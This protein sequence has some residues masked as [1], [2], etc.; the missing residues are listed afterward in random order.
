MYNH[1][2]AEATWSYTENLVSHSKSLDT[3]TGCTH[4]AS[5][6]HPG[7][8][9][10]DAGTFQGADFH[11]MVQASHTWANSSNNSGAVSTGRPRIARIHPKDIQNISE[12]QADCA[13][14]H[15]HHILNVRR[16]SNRPFRPHR[17]EFPASCMAKVSEAC[18]TLTSP[19]PGSRLSSGTSLRSFREPL[20]QG[21]R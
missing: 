17:L 13:H 3:C 10:N 19:W 16:F 5:A 4:L 20:G 9:A 7:A 8:R 6:S 14:I 12:V 15:L 21:I 2:S 11:A 1:I 18:C